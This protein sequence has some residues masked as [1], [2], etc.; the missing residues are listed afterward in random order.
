MGMKVTIKRTAP[1]LHVEELVVESP[2]DDVASTAQYIFRLYMNKAGA[3]SFQIRYHAEG[4]DDCRDLAQHGPIRS[5][6]EIH[7]ELQPKQP[8]PLVDEAPVEPVENG[9]SASEGESDDGEDDEGDGDQAGD[10]EGA[11]EDEDADDDE[12]GA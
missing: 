11:S 10:D 1:A 5:L 8:R 6:A 4:G 12:E 7:E 2:H 3:G 9:D